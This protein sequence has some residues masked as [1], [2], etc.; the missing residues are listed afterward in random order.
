M[1]KNSWWLRLQAKFSGKSA[2]PS[3]APTAPHQPH[4]VTLP[5]APTTPVQDWRS[6]LSDS[7]QGFV[8]CISPVG[9]HRMAYHAWGDSSNPK[10]L[11]CVHGLT[12]RGSDFACVAR[13]LA[14]RYYVVCPDVVGR[15]DSDTLTNPML[16]GIPQYVSDM[17][18]LIAHLKPQQ[19]DWFGTSMG[20]LI[21]MVLA[22]MPQQPLGRLLL[23]DIGP[24]ID[25]AFF[26]R[27]MKYL[28]KP[29]V[30]ET[31]AQALAY[32]NELTL[33]FGQHTPEQLRELNL[34]HI[35]LQGNDWGLH[36]DP[37]INAPIMASNPLQALAAEQALW[38]S[39]DAISIPTLIVR[40]AESDLLSRATVAKMCAR[41]A[42]AR[43]I[44]IPQAGHAPAFILPNHLQ[45]ARE[46]FQ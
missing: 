27:L 43:S 45:I 20:G 30:F 40:G 41:N 19:L 12:R 44:E 6:S 36:Y 23:N 32:V 2:L 11:L 25:P 18:T 38:K 22:G 4:S 10:V 14:D 21:G 39:F 16:Y 42:Q 9:L 17:V 15:G 1:K 26:I 5:V 37:Q 46:F 8:Q 28:S 24:S 3:Q 29:I 33:T 34:P 35:K 7:T 31:Q 13:A